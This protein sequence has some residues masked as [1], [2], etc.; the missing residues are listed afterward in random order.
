MRWITL[1]LVVMA[2]IA[3]ALADEELL[4]FPETK[5]VNGTQLYYN[6][7]GIRSFA[8]PFG[9]SIKVYNAGLWTMSP[10]RTWEDVQKCNGPKHMEFTFLRSVGQSQV[11]QAWQRQCDASVSHVYDGYEKDRDAF[12]RMFGP[13]SSGGSV[14]IQLSGEDTVVV[15]Q[16]IHRGIIRGRNFQRAFLSLW[17]GE[18]AVQA[19]LKAGLLG[20]GL[21][22][23]ATAVC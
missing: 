11:T 2:C 20:C 16:G 23:A 3:G 10:L 1:L 12:I 8:L 9:M 18:K 4:D 13:V 5:H 7:G 21:R 22:E 17:F 15:D 14:Q 6:G 19:S